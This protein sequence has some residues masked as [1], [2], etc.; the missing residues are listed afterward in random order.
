MNPPKGSVPSFE[1]P[2]LEMASVRSYFEPFGA[3]NAGR[4]SPASSSKRPTRI[5]MLHGHGQS[6]QF[7]Y[8]K[9]TRLVEALHEIALERDA[10]RC[11]ERIELFY[12]NGPLSA[13]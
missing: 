12:V 4:N 10:R 11:S 8:H 6:G 9:T 2:L 3:G 7:F 5:L 13:G 1:H